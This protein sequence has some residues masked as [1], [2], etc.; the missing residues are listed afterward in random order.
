MGD[1]TTVTLTVLKAQADAAKVF[2]EYEADEEYEADKFSAFTFYE[3]NY[4]NLDFIAK[5]VAAGIAFNSKWDSGS[6]YGPGTYY[7]RYTS[8]G[9]HKIWEIADSSINPSIDSLV[10][11]LDRPIELHQFIVDHVE[12]TTPLSWDNQLEYGKLFRTIQLIAGASCAV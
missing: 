2:F 5:L 12:N 1:R 10:L 7:S 3:V 6:E 4:G 11:L 8:E 9:E